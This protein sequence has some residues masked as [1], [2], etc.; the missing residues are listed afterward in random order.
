ML[1]AIAAARPLLG[2]IVTDSTNTYTN[3]RY[4]SL[5]GFLAIVTPVLLEQGIAI[6]SYVMHDP[7]RV[8]TFLA[9]VDGRESIFSD[10]PIVA[11]LG[12]EYDSS[13]V[14]KKGPSNLQRVCASI[15]SGQRYNLFALLAVFPDKDEDGNDE[16][17]PSPA[18]NLPGIGQPAQSLPGLPLLANP[19]QP[20]QV[21]PQ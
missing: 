4:L 7:W 13:Q 17:S 8:R 15:T 12:S 16:P 21:L 10:F 14:R 1:E 3:S 6:Y 20:I 19:V 5:P 11:D 2:E 18:H 9:F